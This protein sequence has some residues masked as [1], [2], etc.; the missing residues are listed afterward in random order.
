MGPEC[1]M[2]QEIKMKENL[3][4]G[5]AGQHT[6]ERFQEEQITRNGSTSFDS[7]SLY[8]LFAI[9]IMYF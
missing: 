7:L 3:A 6:C 5:N 4:N 9:L 1:L 8:A 2:H